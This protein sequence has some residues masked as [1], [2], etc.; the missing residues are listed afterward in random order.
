MT[1]RL[2]PAGWTFTTRLVT[3]ALV[4]AFLM[5]VAVNVSLYLVSLDE[6]RVEVRERGQ[7]VAAALSEGSR[8]GV[9]SGN[10][11]SV[12]RTVRGLMLA[13]PSIA[14]VDVL[15]A[16]R[17][18]LVTVH[19][20]EGEGAMATIEVAISAGSIEVDLLDAASAGFGPG[21]V[22]NGP[23]G[24]LAGYVRVTMSPAPL[25]QARR[26]RLLLGSGLV[27][28]AALG[29]GVVGLALAR[30]LRRPLGGV[31]T[32]LRS[33]RQ[34]RFDVPVERTAGGEL[35]E[36]QAAIAEMAR[37]LGITHQQLEDEV[38]RR[39]TQLQEAVRL[40]Q[41]ADD[42]RRRLI[43]RGNELIEDERRRLSLE[44]HDEL[45]AALV[46]V[47][48]QADALAGLAADEGRIESQQAAERISGLIDDL[49][50]R[51]RAIVTR[52]RPEVLDMLGL[53]GGIEEMVR[54][55]DEIHAGCKFDFRVESG[56]PS[57]PEPVAMAA[58]RVVQEALSNVAKH[59]KAT[60]CDVVLVH[61]SSAGQGAIRMVIA[62]NGK[63]Y[64]TTATSVTSAGIGLIGMRERVAALSGVLSMESSPAGTIVT[65]EFPVDSDARPEA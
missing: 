42:E 5:F 6:A 38:R 24:S 64:D 31:M 19:S 45:N 12:E 54:Q 50:R 23:S 14:G 4:P 40:A 59:A 7:I 9:I 39:T 27:L 52:L 30:R 51:A 33:I 57:I 10:T 49:Y 25:L 62:D 44:I 35:G 65:A 55:F 26:S 34:G 41:A 17:R 46:S 18:P 53:A 13:D 47:R 29:S 1:W 15:D 16:S 3:L 56:L 63:G 61:K 37:G 60:Q 21:Q 58:Y 48:L 32:A 22:R 28:L 36:L 8:Y 20:P 11:A 2:R 43:T